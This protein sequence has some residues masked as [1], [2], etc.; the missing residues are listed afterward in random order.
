MK[1]VIVLCLFIIV[2]CSFYNTLKINE[3][4]ECVKESKYGRHGLINLPLEH[5]CPDVFLQ[6]VNISSK[7]LYAQEQ[8]KNALNAKGQGDSKPLDK[9]VELALLKSQLANAKTNAD[10]YDL[11]SQ[12]SILTKGLSPGSVFSDENN[13]GSGGKKQSSSSGSAG[14]NKADKLGPGACPKNRDFYTGD[15]YASGQLANLFAND[16]SNQQATNIVKNV[17]L[18]KSVTIDD[19]QNVI[20]KALSGQDYMIYFTFQKDKYI[21]FIIYKDSKV[22]GKYVELVLD[23]SLDIDPNA[24]QEQDEA[25]TETETKNTT[26]TDADKKQDEDKNKNPI[27]KE[28]NILGVVPHDRIIRPDKVYGVQASSSMDHYT[29]YDLTYDKLSYAPIM[30]HTD[31]YVQNQVCERAANLK[32]DRNLNVKC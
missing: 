23:K 7:D 26:S 13:P 25:E 16:I 20:N 5:S 14:Q 32:K 27:I 10:F 4:F 3:H 12:T 28:C 30:I 9:E 24:V 29:T 19:Y 2:F 6:Q 31:S 15:I 1:L 17:L 11:L 22:S 18:K 8:A 21:E